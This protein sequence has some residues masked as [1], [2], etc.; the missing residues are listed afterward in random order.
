MQFKFLKLT[1]SI[2]LLGG[3]IW[4]L[5]NQQS[6]KKITDSET[7]TQEKENPLARM[8]HEFKMLKSPITGKIPRGIQQKSVQ[9][10]Q[11]TA[12]FQLQKH[13]NQKN[14]PTI[15]V[16]IKGPNNYGGRTRAFAFDVLDSDVIIAGGVSSGIFRSTDNGENWTRV[17]PAGMIHNLTAIA[18][19]T[20]TGQEDTW[21]IGTGERIGNSAEETGA[22]YLGFGMWKSMDNGA[23]WDA[24]DSTQDSDL[25]VFDDDFDY[26]SRIIVNPTNGD[27]LVVAGEVIK[28]STNSGTDW[29][30]ELGDTDT[31]NGQPGD[32][33]YNTASGKFYAAIHGEA[34]NSAGIWS[35][36]D[37]DNW[38]LERTPEQ[39]NSSNTNERVGRMVL[40][41]VA[42]TAGIVVMSQLSTPFN[43]STGGGTSEVGLYHF[44]GNSTWTDHTDKISDC[45]GGSTDPKGI[46]L[47]GAYNMCITT[48]PNDP[49]LVYMGGVEVFSYNLTNNEYTFIGGSQ[50]AASD[51]NLHVDNHLLLFE[52][53]DVLWAGND[54]GLRNTNVATSPLDENGFEWNNKNKDYITYQYYDADIHPDNGSEFVAGAAQ[55]NAFTIQPTTAEAREVGP[56]ADGIAVGIISGTDFNTYTLLAGSQEGGVCRL[57]NGADTDIQ[58]EDRTQGF[59]TKFH[60]DDDNR[61][62][63]YYFGTD[64]MG[65]EQDDSD[66]EYGLQRTRSVSTIADGTITGNSTTGYEDLT[67]ITGAISASVSAMATSRNLQ[68]GSAYTA[69]DVNRKAYFGTE[70][71]KVYR[72]N[73]PAFAAANTTPIN[74]TPTGSNGYVSDIAVNPMDDKEVIVTYSNYDTPS[75]WHTS[76]ASVATPTWTNIE[77]AS[78]SAVEI[79][80]AR[81]A[82]IVNTN[83][84]KVYLV[85]TSAGL[86]G[87]DALSGATTTWTK[88]GTNADIGLAVCSEMRL[89]TSDNK[90]ALGTHGNGLFLLSLP[91]SL[92]VE[93]IS[94]TGKAT[95]D[96]NLLKWTTAT[97]E[98]NQGFEIQKSTDGESFAKIGFVRGNGFSY[99]AQSYEFLDKTTETG[100]IYYRLK[101]IDEGRTYQYSA[102]INITR[103]EDKTEDSMFSFYPNPVIDRLT[104]ENGKGIA[105]IYNISGQLMLSVPIDDNKQQIDV[106]SLPKGNYV[107]TLHQNNGQLLTRS[108]V[109]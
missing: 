102:A 33:I 109:K 100:L 6:V 14:I 74:I 4:Y 56:T 52:N 3:L 48:K 103:D 50:L 76:D 97:E 44:D 69:S 53:D 25:E 86:Y 15:N 32:I 79:S 18:Q 99:T 38:T 89:R 70:D 16:S 68:Y 57:V 101:Q 72:L 98:F 34:S 87:T 105:T 42:N 46:S 39:L 63:F 28:R 30:D 5:T 2:C 26:I 10:A 71:G 106:A 84:T 93:L 94:F 12:S 22:T 67:G 29:D 13:P 73:D 85:G 47:Q 77:G 58:P 24:L 35:S 78:G 9:I 75:V 108:F 66:D 55:D 104:V 41:N 92:S 21:Y 61:N 88:V 62:I 7:K 107:L 95:Q 23:T 64:Q 20:R 36:T 8:E 54:G 91:T 45:A 40:A 1:I 11:K 83:A 96:G 31:N 51:I 90:V 49:N 43:C 37:G 81:S 17:T 60:L 82:L 59:N 19:D 80:S 65:T 27:V